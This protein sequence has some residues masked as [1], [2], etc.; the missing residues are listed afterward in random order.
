MLDGHHVVGSPA[1]DG[2]G[3]VMLGV[4]RVDRQD[5]AGQVGKRLQQFP[6]R[7]DLI[8]LRIHGDLA[9][10]RADAVRQGRDQVRG[11]PA[12]ALRAADGLAVDRD[13]QPPAG[14]HRPGMQ[15]GSEHPVEHVGADQ[16]E[17]A[18]VGG[19][20]RRAAFRSEC[21]QHVRA[22]VARPLP[23]C[24]ERLRPRDDRRDSHCEQPRQRMP[25]ASLLPRVRDLGKEIEKM[26]AAGS[27]HGRRC[28]RRAVSLVAGD[29]EREE[30]PSFRP[31]PSAARGHAGRIVRRNDIAGHALNSGLCRVP[32]LVVTWQRSS[33]QA[34]A[35]PI[36]IY[37]GV[38]PAYSWNRVR[39]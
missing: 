16:G 9:E 26:L 33:S 18:P 39:R 15:P 14:P 27:R 3:G 2:A 21:G 24:R 12:L 30:L 31:G 38:S 11:L 4:H 8:G 35:A 29:G 23:D 32:G 36:G 20:L 34:R 28:H 5:C 17:R 1:E 13:H 6:H 22:G 10:D 37:T 7:G 19:L 25:A